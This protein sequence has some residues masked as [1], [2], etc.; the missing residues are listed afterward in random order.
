MLRWV[1][2]ILIKP[3]YNNSIL[4]TNNSTNS[5]KQIHDRLLTSMKL[6]H[7]QN[8]RFQVY[9]HTV[10]PYLL[11]RLCFIADISSFV[12]SNHLSTNYF[13]NIVQRG[14]HIIFFRSEN[15]VLGLLLNKKLTHLILNQDFQKDLKPD[16][17]LRYI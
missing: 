13:S 12:N 16:I 7:I 6:R 8:N 17:R 11:K 5:L 2:H 10:Q 4:I 1:L 15:L 9:Y 14:A 3:K